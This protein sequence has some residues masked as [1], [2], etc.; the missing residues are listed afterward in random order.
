MGAGGT[1]LTLAR[2]LA[3]RLQLS[4]QLPSLSPPDDHSLAPLPTP[5]SV[6]HSVP[7]QQVHP[8]PR[9]RRRQPPI[10]C[11]TPLHD[12]HMVPPSSLMLFS[13]FLGPPRA[14]VCQASP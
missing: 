9:Q 3:L 6:W 13:H 8:A 14:T 7:R 5:L 2:T 12:T 10:R 11:G 4:L 1:A